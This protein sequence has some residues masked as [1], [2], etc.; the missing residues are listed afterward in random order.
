MITGIDVNDIVRY[1]IDDGYIDDLYED[2]VTRISINIDTGEHTIKMHSA[3]FTVDL[4]NNIHFDGYKIIGVWT[5]ELV[6]ING[7][8]ELVF[9]K[10]EPKFKTY[11]FYKKPAD[12]DVI[13]LPKYVV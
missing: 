5:Q 1:T 3:E 6:K 10:K 8:L 12:D 4:Q 9:R 13:E 2:C 11:L 7:Q